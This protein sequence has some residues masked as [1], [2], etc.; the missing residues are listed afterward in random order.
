MSL[1]SSLICIGKHAGQVS[2]KESKFFWNCKT[3]KVYIEK[4]G[5]FGSSMNDT[6]LMAQSVDEAYGL[7]R[8]YLMRR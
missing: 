8:V 7:V 5:F 1:N 4:P 3:R 2:R 6:G